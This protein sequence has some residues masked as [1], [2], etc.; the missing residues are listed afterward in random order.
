M[1]LQNIFSD[2][3]AYAKE[4]I[5]AEKFPNTSHIINLAKC[6]HCG[7][8]PMEL[9]I[10]HHNGSN[11]KNFRG[12]IWACCTQCGEKNRI[13]SFTSAHRRPDRKERPACKCKND[14]F[15]VLECERIERDEGIPGFFDEGVV[16]GQCSEC[17]KN[18]AFVYMD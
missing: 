7:V 17:G 18:Q 6:V 2:L 3:E 11:Y 4:L 13:F 14:R 5:A 16:V 1:N 15:I 12:V 8:V 9:I 10:E